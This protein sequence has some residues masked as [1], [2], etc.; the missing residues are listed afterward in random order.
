MQ[1]SVIGSN[2]KFDRVLETLVDPKLQLVSVLIILAGVKF[3]V[4]LL[5]LIGKMGTG[6][7]LPGPVG[8][9]RRG[10]LE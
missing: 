3:L 9:L 8:L 10:G 7:A 1:E 5:G 4:F 6:R 2:W